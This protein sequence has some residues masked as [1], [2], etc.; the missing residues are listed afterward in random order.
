[1]GTP[2]GRKAKKTTFNFAGRK[3]D[4]NI[5]QVQTVN[6]SVIDD[7]ISIIKSDITEVNCDVIVNAA[8]VT[9]LSGGGIDKIIHSKAGNVLLEKCKRLP[10]KDNIDGNDV[11]CFPGQCEVTDTVG[12]NLTNCRYVYHTVGPDICNVSDMSYN[13]SILRC[14]YESCLQKMLDTGMKSLA[15]CC[16]STGIFGYPNED[17]AKIAWETVTLW[18]EKNYTSVNKI[19]FCT[20]KLK[21]YEI[22]L[23][24]SDQ[25][26]R[27][28][29][30]DVDNIKMQK[31]IPKAM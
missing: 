14:C 3:L 2:K 15:F 12:T 17:A 23:K 1:M 6:S 18:L 11:R 5:S 10:V 31:S 9:M 13:A 4:M 16:I 20:Y 30:V 7:K 24:L 27:S 29:I 25:Y 22:Y 19:I 28:N 26:G 8:N 21:D